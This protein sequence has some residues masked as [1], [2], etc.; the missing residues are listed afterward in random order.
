METDSYIW[1]K[2]KYWRPSSYI[3]PTSA[4]AFGFVSPEFFLFL[5]HSLSKRGILEKTF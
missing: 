1:R 4:V 3:V 2:K 5:F